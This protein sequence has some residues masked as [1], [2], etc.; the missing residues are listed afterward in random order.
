MKSVYSGLMYKH[1]KDSDLSLFIDNNEFTAIKRS[2]SAE[3]LK[4][5]SNGRVVNIKKS[6]KGSYL[7]PF[8]HYYDAKKTRI[9]YTEVK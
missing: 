5:Y 9:I 6:D 8:S 1:D 2:D 3:Y 7:V 4:S